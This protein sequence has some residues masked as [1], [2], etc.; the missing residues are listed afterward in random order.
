MTH[1]DPRAHHGCK[2]LQYQYAYGLILYCCTA[3]R[4]RGY[5][6]ERSAHVGYIRYDLMHATFRRAGRCTRCTVLYV[7]SK[8]RGFV[9][10]IEPDSFTRTMTRTRTVKTVGLLNKAKYSND[11]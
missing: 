5:Q 1:A 10:F 9:S 4:R 3:L 11:W 8:R 2:V 6:Y 7:V